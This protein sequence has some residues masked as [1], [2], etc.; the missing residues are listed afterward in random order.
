MHQLSFI[1]SP[2]LLERRLQN[3]KNIRGIDIPEFIMISS[4]TELKV[5][6]TPEIEEVKDGD[7][8]LDADL[9]AE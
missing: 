2:T 3:F 5:Q 7:V 6:K 4:P 9:K 8:H 1:N